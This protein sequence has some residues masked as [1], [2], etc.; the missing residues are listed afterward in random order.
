VEDIKPETIERAAEKVGW[1]AEMLTKN[2]RVM[3]EAPL[4]FWLSVGICSGLIGLVIY[5]WISSLYAAEIR[6]KDA[7]VKSLETDRDALKR[8]LEEAGISSTP[9]KKRTLILATQLSEYAAN[10]P[11]N[12]EGMSLWASFG[13][14]FGRRIE[15]L[16]DE[17]DEHGVRSEALDKIAGTVF[18]ASQFT[19]TSVQLL[20]NELNR[21]AEKV[22]D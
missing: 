8:R 7:T 9:L 18:D 3:I 21:L 11:K 19:P 1:W 20:A 15:K 22:K 12:A 4:A 10:W 5:L 16:R 2:R 13:G 14:R 17:L 6:A